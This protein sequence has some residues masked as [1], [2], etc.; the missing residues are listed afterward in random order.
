MHLDQEWPL[1]KP[2]VIKLLLRGSALGDKKEFASVAEGH[3]EADSW[4]ISSGIR[5]PATANSRPQDG[6]DTQ[7][8]LLGLQGFKLQMIANT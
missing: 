3:K 6:A 4:S 7:R 2:E 5:A 1:T 8:V